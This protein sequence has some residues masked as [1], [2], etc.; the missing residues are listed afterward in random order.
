MDLGETMGDL[1][2]VL[3][4]LVMA[5]SICG[6]LSGIG[7]MVRS[8]L[9]FLINIIGAILVLS[10]S[11]IH[12]VVAFLF[13]PAY[14]LVMV[15]FCCITFGLLIALITLLPKLMKTM[16]NACLY[17]NHINYLIMAFFSSLALIITVIWI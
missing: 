3:S 17:M 10:G 11:I 12:V 2:V 6:L 4:M 13:S 15:A 14:T 9:G 7:L 16:Q 8:G 5:F 1:E